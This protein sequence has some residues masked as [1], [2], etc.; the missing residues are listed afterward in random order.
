GRGLKAPWLADRPGH[1]G[2]HEACDGLRSASQVACQTLP[3]DPGDGGRTGGSR[4]GHART[5]PRYST[6]TFTRIARPATMAAN[7]ERRDDGGQ[8]AATEAGVAVRPAC[9]GQDDARARACG[10]LWRGAAQPG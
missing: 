9:I 2:S 7:E 6:E 8:H 3:A 4:S 1:A 5:S 10:R